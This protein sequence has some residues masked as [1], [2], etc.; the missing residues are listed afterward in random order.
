MFSSVRA[1][2]IST[3][4]RDDGAG[5]PPQDALHA[6]LGRE[7]STRQRDHDR[8]VAT[9]QDVDEDDLEDCRP[10]QRLE[11]SSTWN[12]QQALFVKPE[13][14]REDRRQ[15]RR[16]KTRPKENGLVSPA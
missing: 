11:N 8:V 7:I 13:K 12:P 14:Y 6:L 16:G 15:P 4:R 5:R 10:T 9:Q 2:A 1:K 3:T